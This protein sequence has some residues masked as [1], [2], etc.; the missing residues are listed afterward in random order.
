MVVNSKFSS[1]SLVGKE[2]WRA[3]F[4][5]DVCYIQKFAAGEE[6]RIQFVSDTGGFVAGYIDGR[7]NGVPV[8]VH[9]LTSDDDRS[10]FEAVF[11]VDKAGDYDFY[12]AGSSFYDPETFAVDGYARVCGNVYTARFAVRPVCDLRDTMLISYTHRRPEYD[13]IFEQRMFNLRVEGGIY[14]GDKTQALNNEVFRDQRFMPYQTAAESYEVSVLTVGT[15]RGVPQWVGNKINSIFKL[16]D[17]YVDGVRTVRNESSVPELI[18]AGT[19]YPLYVFK[20]NVEQADGERLRANGACGVF[21]TC[22]GGEGE[23]A[24]GKSAVGALVPPGVAWKDLP[25][26]K[27]IRL[28]APQTGFTSVQGDGGTLIAPGFIV[29]DDMTVYALY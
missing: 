19:R 16:S 2:Q 17:V 29:S 3:P 12:L 4:D 8:S 9:T 7:G 20:L 21:V 11:S 23:T 6:I 26:P 28:G 27:F 10:L 5:R 14:P 25:Q 15:G 24:D 22:H 13:T 1:L 18:Q